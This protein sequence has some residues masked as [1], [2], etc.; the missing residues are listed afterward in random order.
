[1]FPARG[2]I[3]MAPEAMRQ[4]AI[5]SRCVWRNILCRFRQIVLDGALLISEDSVEVETYFTLRKY[6]TF[7]VKFH[8]TRRSSESSL[9][10]RMGR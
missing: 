2:Y 10:R 9:P 6:S 5:A 3:R 1:M 7:A 4:V 8:R